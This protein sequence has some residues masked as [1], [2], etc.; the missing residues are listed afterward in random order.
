MKA[1]LLC[2]I[3]AL[4]LE[5]HNVPDL[6]NAFIK[7]EPSV[8]VIHVNEIIRRG[9]TVLLNRQGLG[10][11]RDYLG[12]LREKIHIDTNFLDSCDKAFKAEELTEIVISEKAFAPVFLAT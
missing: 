2:L 1:S 8:S 3:M 10:A 6:V 11:V 4:D 7:F 5:E 9:M 12:E